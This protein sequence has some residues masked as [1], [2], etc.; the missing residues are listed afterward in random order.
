MSGQERCPS[1][2]G[3]SGL[4]LVPSA[5]GHPDRNETCSLSFSRPN[6]GC[7]LGLQDVV[8]RER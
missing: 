5:E 3:H 2:G 7:F 8:A 6:G 1:W 4:T